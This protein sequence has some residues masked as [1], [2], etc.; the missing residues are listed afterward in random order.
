[1]TTESLMAYFPRCARTSKY[2]S[3]PVD[4]SRHDEARS[5][6]EHLCALPIVGA[7]LVTGP[8]HRHRT[9]LKEARLR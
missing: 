6:Q 7:R 4:H 1:M 3:V 8:T 2:G 5:H 9:A